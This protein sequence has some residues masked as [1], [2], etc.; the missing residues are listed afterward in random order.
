MCR[1][2]CIACLMVCTTGCV[3]A[4]QLI[5]NG[6][7]YASGSSQNDPM[8]SKLGDAEWRQYQSEEQ[9]I[10]AIDSTQRGY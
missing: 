10:A 2:L 5:H 3:A 9:N 4:R 6:L 8:R 7:S 1:L